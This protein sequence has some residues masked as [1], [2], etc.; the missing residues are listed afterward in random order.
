[1]FNNEVSSIDE[2]SA[3][4]TSPFK[5]HNYYYVFLFNAC[6]TTK[7]RRAVLATNQTLQTL[8]DDDCNREIHFIFLSLFLFLSNEMTAIMKKPP[9]LCK[10]IQF[11]VRITPICS[12]FFQKTLVLYIERAH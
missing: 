9:L 7:T 8:M 6:K 12:T 3:R 1:M 2:H 10:K 4:I 5:P 11:D